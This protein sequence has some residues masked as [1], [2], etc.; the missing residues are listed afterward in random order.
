MAVTAGVMMRSVA[1][2]TAGAPFH[3]P[4]TWSFTNFLVAETKNSSPPSA[5]T[6]G[7]STSASIDARAFGGGGMANYTTSAAGRH[8]KCRWWIV[9]RGP[10]RDVLEGQRRRVRLARVRPSLPHDPRVVE[11]PAAGLLAGVGRF[12]L[13]GWRFWRAA[14]TTLVMALG[15]GATPG[16]SAARVSREV[17]LKQIAQL[18]VNGLPFVTT[19]ALVLGATMMIQTRAA[20]PGVPGELMGKILAAVVLRELAPLLTALIVAAR[21]GAAMATDVGTMRASLE[22]FGLESM[23]V[24]PARYVV[25]PRLIAAVTGVL[26]LTVYFAVLAI[27]STFGASAVLEAPPL[28]AMRDGLGQALGPSDLLLYVI[29]GV[30]SGTLVGWLCCHFGMQVR[31]SATEVPAM[32]G[33][34]V[35]YSALACVL[36][37]FAVTVSYYAVVGLPGF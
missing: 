34:A 36:F 26:V 13:A 11:T 19:T 10:A 14:A 2:C 4:P 22:L 20:A 17:T 24:D 30:G 27:A 6:R 33:R 21:S 7:A 31:S 28:D 12:G 29:R 23:G 35:M 25:R 16:R 9:R 3:E 8:V 32:T 5:S 37:N 1:I 15:A 18:G